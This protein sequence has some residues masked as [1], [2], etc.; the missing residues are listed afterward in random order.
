MLDPERRE[1]AVKFSHETSQKLNSSSIGCLNSLTISLSSLLLNPDHG[2]PC[3]F[4]PI[5][6]EKT[7]KEGLQDHQ[8]GLEISW[9]CKER[10]KGSRQMPS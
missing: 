9:P 4:R 6:S 2:L 7:L 3:K 10:C 8:E 5:G 1:R